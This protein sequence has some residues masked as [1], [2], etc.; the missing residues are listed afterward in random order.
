MSAAVAIAALWLAFALTHIGLASA[1]LRP[2]LVEALGDR[3]YQGV[4]SLVSLATFLPLVWVYVRSRNAGPLLWTLEPGPVTAAVLALG[5]GLAVVLGVAG[6]ITPS[7]VSLIGGAPEPRGV[8]LITR[9][10]LFMGIGLFGFFH[11]IS[12]GSAPAV[13]FF[14]GFPVFAVIGCW[15]QDQRKRA[16]EGEKL[17]DFYARTALLPFTGPETLRGLREFSPLALA[18]GIGLA[19]VSRLLH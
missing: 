4:Y 11:L 10:P 12:S 18:V 17:R 3:G 19:V 6:L 8:Q 15:H 9:H 13:A 16:T 7:P 2:R 14:V 5:M 1:K